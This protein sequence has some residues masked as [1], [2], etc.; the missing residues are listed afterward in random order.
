MGSER[1]QQNRKDHDILKG[2]L[3][4]VQGCNP[5]PPGVFG[6][7]LPLLSITKGA[8]DGP[9][10]CH[11]LPPGKVRE[12]P[13]T[14]THRP[15]YFQNSRKLRRYFQKTAELKKK[16]ST[17]ALLYFVKEFFLLHNYNWFLNV[18]QLCST[19]TCSITFMR[20]ICSL[21]Y[22][23]PGALKAGLL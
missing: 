17:P 22:S 11:A 14:L 18:K 12:G 19:Y 1:E 2:G 13:G 3:R 8:S 10:S 6:L 9:N 4:L 5:W 23:L 15:S 16:K 20:Q 7:F 21:F